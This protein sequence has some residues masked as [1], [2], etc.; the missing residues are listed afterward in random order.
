LGLRGNI[1]CNDDRD[2][3]CAEIHGGSLGAAVRRVKQLRG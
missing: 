3:Q 2:D 1:D